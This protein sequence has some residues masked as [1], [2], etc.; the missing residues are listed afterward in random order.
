MFSTAALKFQYHGQSLCWS[1]APKTA[2][3]RQTDRW[4]QRQVKTERGTHWS[5]R[6]TDRLEEG[7]CSSDGAASTFL[8]LTFERSDR[9]DRQIRDRLTDRQTDRQKTAPSLL[10]R[11]S[12]RSFRLSSWERC[13]L[14]LRARGR[15]R[16]AGRRSSGSSRYRSRWRLVRR[17][18]RR[19]TRKG[20]RRRGTRCCCT[21]SAGRNVSLPHEPRG[22]AGRRWSQQCPR[23]GTCSGSRRSPTAATERWRAD[24]D[25]DPSLYPS[26]PCRT[27]TTMRTG[28]GRTWSSH[29]GG[30]WCRSVWF[31]GKDQK[32]KSAVRCLKNPK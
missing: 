20:R 8:F 2:S 11:G 25:T 29:H 19:T 18:R 27:R 13:C 16:L 26:P 3:Q 14:C 10:Q 6:T 17:K 30:W 23:P 31:D 12:R 32:E 24:T 22:R 9:N 28:E 7:G 21:R 4:R 5:T 1:P 15:L